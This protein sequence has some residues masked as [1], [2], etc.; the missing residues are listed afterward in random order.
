MGARGEGEGG[1]IGHGYCDVLR[2]VAVKEGSEWAGPGCTVFREV[3]GLRDI[4]VALCE[5][6][7]R[8]RLILNPIG[9]GLSIGSIGLDQRDSIGLEY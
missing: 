6:T 9:L 2:Q 8:I 5:R 3:V 7:Y 4:V 1:I